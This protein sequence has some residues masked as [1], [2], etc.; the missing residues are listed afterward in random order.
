M[1]FES[2]GFPIEITKELAQEKGISINLDEFDQAYKN[3]Q[4]KSQTASK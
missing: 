2:Y 3:H 4:L 1:L